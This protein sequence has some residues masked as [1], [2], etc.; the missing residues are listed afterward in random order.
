MARI[1]YG[2][3]GEGMGHAMRSRVIIEHLAER[4]DVQV[5]VSG[6]AHDYLKARER[7]RLGVKRIWGLSILYEDN[8][9]LGLRTALYNL[10]GAAFGGWPRNVRAYLEL[11]ERFRPDVVISDFESWSHLFAK[12]RGLPVFSV[13]NN[14]IVNRC[15]HPPE[16]LA[17]ARAAWFA[18]RSVV[19]AK[20][21]R[22]DHYLVSTFFYP[23]VAKPRTTLV[24]PVLRPEILA[25]RAEQGDHLLVY[26]TSTSNKALP[27]ILRRSGI[28]CRLYGVRRDLNRE[29]REGNLLW[30]PFSEA[31]FVEDLRTARAV[32]SGG[33]FT[34]MS[35]AVY[36]HKPMLSVP[37]RMQFEQILNARWLE[38][39]GY[40]RA[41]D[42]ITP[43][44]LAEFLEGLPD[45]AGAL[46]GYRQDGNRVLLETLDGHLAAA[47]GP[48]ARAAAEDP[49][50]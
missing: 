6:R 8:A 48:K 23:P 3:A 33:S 36:L 42:R 37:V 18:G 41:A 28:E 21:P 15:E 20:L 12:T 39:L 25:A 30:R 34:L 38:R 5:V 4:H 43:R 45:H 46:A 32:V 27:D 16:I 17:G 10:T 40:G 47:L 31:T 11:V 2:V 49:L 22:C 35:E 50:A 14:Q 26:Q 9:V 29:V 19:R 1:L 24:P 7:D 13:D 44:A